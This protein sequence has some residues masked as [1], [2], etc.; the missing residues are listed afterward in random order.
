MK[1]DKCISIY[2]LLHQGKV[3]QSQTLDATAPLGFP[4]NPMNILLFQWPEA[5]DEEAAIEENEDFPAL[6]WHALRIAYTSEDPILTEDQI[7]SICNIQVRG[8]NIC[9]IGSPSEE[10]AQQIIKDVAVKIVND[11]RLIAAKRYVFLFEF[12]CA[13]VTYLIFQLIS[14]LDNLINSF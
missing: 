12:Q 13:Y 9:G 10:I 1:I 5:N 2:L 11:M 3:L 7:N 14:L 4:I 6:G 8:Q